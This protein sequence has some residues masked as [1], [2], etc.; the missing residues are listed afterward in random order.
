MDIERRFFTREIRMETDENGQR[1]LIGYG[2]V[3]EQLSEDLGGFREMIKAGAFAQAIREDDVRSL[4]NHDFNLVLG[5]NRAKTLRLAEDEEGL[6]YEIDLPDTSYANDLVASME[7]GDVDQSSFGFRVVEESWREPTDDQPYPIRVLHQV[8]L[9]DV[10]PVTIPAYPQTS[11]QVRSY[12]KENFTAAGGA[13]G[14]GAEPAHVGRLA[15]L[16]RKLD[17]LERI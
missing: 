12:I 8:K 3:F 1:K 5:R 7:R 16:K 17:L 9:Y 4:F 6:R 11:A 10:G 15:R 13:T 14:G 2:A